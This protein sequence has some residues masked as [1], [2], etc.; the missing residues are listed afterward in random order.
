M[1]IAR[2]NPWAMPAGSMPN[3]F[4][5]APHSDDD[6]SRAAAKAI[7]PHIERLERS[8]LVALMARPMSAQAL[9]AA[10][11]LAGNS[12]RPRLVSLRAKGLAE[13]GEY[14]TTL[15][16]RSAR[17]WRLTDKGREVIG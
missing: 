11:G 8:V 15:S 14:T 2:V 10:T 5:L 17:V 12:V 6:T 4:T 16:G 13:Q 9:E 7:V 1:K 3:L